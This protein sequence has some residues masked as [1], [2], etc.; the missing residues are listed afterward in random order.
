MILICEKYLRFLDK[1]A[2]WSGVSS[3]YDVS[4]LLNY[5]IYHKLT[6][7]YGDKNT[8]DINIGFG[9]LQG[10]W[11]TFDSSRL[12]QSYYEK[13]KPDH[14]KVIHEDWKDRKELYDYYVNYDT[15]FTMVQG[16]PLKC[17][18]YVEYFKEIVS[19][20]KNFEGK[21]SPEKHNCPNFFY[22]LKNKNPV[23]KLKNL[24]PS[25]RGDSLHSTVPNVGV[26]PHGVDG[27]L[28]Y[29]AGSSRDTQSTPQSSDIQTK[30]TNSVL[31]AAPVL[32]TGTML[33][34]YTPLGPWIRTLGG[35]RTNRMNA[36]ETFSPYTP[37]TGDMFS[38]ESANHISYQPM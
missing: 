11:S 18:E 23:D 5:W 24:S 28:P 12:E 27:A 4:L 33:Y 29:S 35:G 17:E 15:L 38:D 7:I 37:E 8:N 13:C 6:N 16:Y 22:E 26:P 3:F 30:V 1:S 14:T 21:C 32:F 10:K 9:V 31:G 25:M 36:M 20:Y 34:R 2:S 19:V